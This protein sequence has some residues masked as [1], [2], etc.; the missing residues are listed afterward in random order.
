MLGA[1]EIMIEPISF[2][3][4]QRQHLLGAWR[5]VVHGFFTH[6]QECSYLSGLSNLPPPF[7]PVVRAAGRFTFRKCSRTMS[8][9]S[10]SR[11]S[12][13]SFSECCF[14]KCAGCVRM[15]NSC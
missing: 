2:L 9:L 8:A 4:G 15:N 13:E 6:I 11:S 12:A 1:D 10:K 3:P 14:C 5:E 7:V